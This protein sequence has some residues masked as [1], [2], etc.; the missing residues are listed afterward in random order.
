MGQA[1]MSGGLS[2]RWELEKSG[3]PTAEENE[4][5]SSRLAVGW[6]LGWVLA[7]WLFVTTLN[8]RKMVF[9]LFFNCVGIKP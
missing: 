8:K 5:H 1:S 2:G 4:L 7:E 9:V 3:G 6:D